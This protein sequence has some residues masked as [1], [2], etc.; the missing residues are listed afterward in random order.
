VA[1]EGG[2]GSARES[3]DL[4]GLGALPL[5]RACSRAK[6]WAHPA[7]SHPPPS[8]PPQ[9]LDVAVHGNRALARVRHNLQPRLLNAALPR[10]GGLPAWAKRLATFPFIVAA[11][12][13]FEVRGRGGIEGLGGGGGPGGPRG[14]RGWELAGDSLPLHRGCRVH[15]RGGPPGAAGSFLGAGGVMSS[16]GNGVRQ[17]IGSP[18]RRPAARAQC[19]AL[20]AANFPRPRRPAPPAARTRRAASASSAG[21]R[22]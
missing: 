16:P 11:E 8:C 22:T 20:A 21:W 9:V 19:P 18:G 13:T 2:A 14:L 6:L 15:V 3:I 7:P 10:V 12:L 4:R 17:P 5:L 1:G